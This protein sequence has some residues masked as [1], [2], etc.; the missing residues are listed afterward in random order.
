MTNGSL[1]TLHDLL[2][3][4]DVPPKVT[5]R[6]LF[7]VLQEIYRQMSLQDQQREEL[8]EKVEAIGKQLDGLEQRVKGL[9]ERHMQAPSITWLLQNKTLDTIKWM[10]FFLF[11]ALLIM[12]ASEPLR[13]WVMGIVGAGP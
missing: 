2:L 4:G 13:L 12:A 10:L 6:I 7:G 3:N 9:E 1:D 8:I 11:I 5:N